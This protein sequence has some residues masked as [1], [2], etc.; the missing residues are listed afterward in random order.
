MTARLADAQD[1]CLRAPASAVLTNNGESFVWIV[2]ATGTVSLRKVTLSR[3]EG[4]FCVTDGLSAGTKIA[5]AG[6]HSL[7][8]GQRV[9]IEQDVTP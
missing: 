6:I 2:D 5:T 7:K 8:Q 4:G 1:A 9:R 3:D